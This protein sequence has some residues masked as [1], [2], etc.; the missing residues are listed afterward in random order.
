MARIPRSAT[1]GAVGKMPYEKRA[2][3]P[4]PTT[5]TAAS[6]FT[7]TEELLGSRGL[8]ELTVEQILQ[9]A[10]VSRTTFY[11]N[12]GSKYAV[13]SGMLEALQAELVDVMQ[14]WFTRGDRAPQDALRDA[15]T[16]V[17]VIWMRHRPILRASAE[18]WHAEPEVGEPWA[19]MMNGFISDIARQ[20]D[21]ERRTGAAPDGVDS[22]AL[23]RTLVWSSERMLYLAGFGICGSRLELD[24][25]DALIVMWAATVYRGL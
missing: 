9:R 16:S 12:F 19:A 17:A 21:T 15:I 4:R 23:A 13:V 11:R 24:A 10:R 5:A 6:I 8:A 18:N 2:S 20:I 7:A 1:H 14:P 22:T 3:A 25:V